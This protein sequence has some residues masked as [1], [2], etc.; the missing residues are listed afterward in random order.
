MEKD[1]SPDHLAVG[2]NCELSLGGPWLPNSN[3]FIRNSQFLLFK[4]LP[5][6]EIFASK[7]L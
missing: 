2:Y 1:S 7:E 4:I 5:E 3:Y 6:G